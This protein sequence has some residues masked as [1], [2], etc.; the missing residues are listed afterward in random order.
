M[1]RAIPVVQTMAPL[2][3]P[4]FGMR[5]F[6][7]STRVPRPFQA[8]A[9]APLCACL[10]GRTASLPDRRSRLSFTRCLGQLIAQLRIRIVASSAPPA[11]KIVEH[12]MFS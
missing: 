6:V 1:A 11:S 8:D 12:F 4:Q 3:R 5:G 2:A 10:A 7:G 9:M